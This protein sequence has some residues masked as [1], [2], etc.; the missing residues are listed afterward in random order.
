MRGEWNGLTGGALGQAGKVPFERPQD[1]FPRG[2]GSSDLC[3]HIRLGDEVLTVRGAGPQDDGWDFAVIYFAFMSSRTTSSV[4][5]RS[6]ALG[7][8]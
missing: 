5:L 3:C 2:C 8:T 1:T 7:T 6:E 4:V